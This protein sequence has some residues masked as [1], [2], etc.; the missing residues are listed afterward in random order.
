[1][2]KINHRYLKC[3]MCGRV[4]PP[5]DRFSYSLVPAEIS[6]EEEVANRL[7]GYLQFTRSCANCEKGVINQEY[8]KIWG[9]RQQSIT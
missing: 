1:M 4:Y 9:R 6:L 5:S 3:T 2:E 8:H 7:A